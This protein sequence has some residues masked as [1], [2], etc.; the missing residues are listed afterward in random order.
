VNLKRTVCRQEYLW[1]E[2]FLV[3]DENS[4]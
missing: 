4:W 2:E 1:W 3:N